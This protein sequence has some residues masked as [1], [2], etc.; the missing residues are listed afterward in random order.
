MEH[1]NPES[2]WHS[3]AYDRDLINR[4]WRFAA[5]IDGNDPELW[6]KDEFGAWIHKLDYGRRH[7]EFGWEICD[8]SFGTGIAGIV[9]LRPMQWQNYVDHV[10]ATTQSKITADGLR[11]IRKLL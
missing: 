10:A 8:T 7:S 4:V 2:D 9:A 3:Q 11:N 1:E 6:R 5:K